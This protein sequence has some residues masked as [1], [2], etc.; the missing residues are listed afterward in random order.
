[1][2]HL[3][4]ASVGGLVALGLGWMWLAEG[5]ALLSVAMA[6]ALALAAPWLTEAAFSALWGAFTFPL[7]ATA[8][9]WLAHGGVLLWPGAALLALAGLVVPVIAFRILKMWIGG[10][11]AVKT[12]AAI[13]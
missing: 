13:A 9:F 11:L 4:A 3:A 10:Q 12:N 8:G 7:A 1:M 2:L 5:L 6:V